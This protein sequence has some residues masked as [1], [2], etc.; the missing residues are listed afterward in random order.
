MNTGTFCKIKEDDDDE[1]IFLFLKLVIRQLIESK[2][3]ALII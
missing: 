2:L 1:L 3:I